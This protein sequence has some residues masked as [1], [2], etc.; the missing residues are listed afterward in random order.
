MLPWFLSS[1]SGPHRRKGAPGDTINFHD[2]TDTG[3]KKKK[4]KLL[5]KRKSEITYKKVREQFRCQ[6]ISM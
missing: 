6:N 3:R 2:F 1:P 4:D 5:I